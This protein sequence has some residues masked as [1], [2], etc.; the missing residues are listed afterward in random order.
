[1]HGPHPTERIRLRSRPP[2]HA[3]VRPGRGGGRAT[4]ARDRGVPRGR[5]RRQTRQGPTRGLRRGDP[6]PR[7][8]DRRVAVHPG[9][10]A[11]AKVATPQS[12]AKRTQLR[13]AR[14]AA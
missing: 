6:R 10:K 3:T 7:R 1:M 12:A 9:V 5:R 11:P 2:R 14:L 8:R 4:G 13:P